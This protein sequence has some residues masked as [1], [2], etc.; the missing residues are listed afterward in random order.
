[1]YTIKFTSA[2]KK[3]YKRMKKR[4]LEII[5]LDTVVA[6][7]ANGKQLDKKYRDHS[8]KGEFNGFR[9]CHVKPDWL[10]I[11]LIEQE[12]LTLTLINTGTHADLLDM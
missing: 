10:L 9:E 8:L 1:M 11:Y 3:N 7:L 4:G 12:V 2:Y 5:L 6:D